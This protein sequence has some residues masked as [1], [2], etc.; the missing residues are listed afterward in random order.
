[1]MI[2]ITLKRMMTKTYGIKASSAMTA[3]GGACLKWYTGWASARWPGIRLSIRY[4]V[5]G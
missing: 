2:M 4:P 1:M 5:R 3:V